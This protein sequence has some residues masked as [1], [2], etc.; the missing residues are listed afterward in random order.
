MIFDAAGNLW[1]RGMNWEGTLVV[2]NTY[3]NSATF[4]SNYAYRPHVYLNIPE[5]VCT[6]KTPKSLLL[7]GKQS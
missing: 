4:Q 2:D 1:K 5:P 3:W 7:T 6:S